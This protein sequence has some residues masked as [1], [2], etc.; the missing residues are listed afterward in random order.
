LLRAATSD[1]L[2]RSVVERRKSPYPQTQDPEYV[3]ALAKQ[4]RELLSGDHPVFE[5][6]DRHALEPM[7]STADATA[8]RHLEQTLSM[9]TWL[10]LYQPDLRLT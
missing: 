4:V 10:D 5:L 2:P 9:A 1:V 3:V 8:R 6:V 7:V